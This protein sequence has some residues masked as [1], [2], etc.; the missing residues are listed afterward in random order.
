MTASHS[1]S[2]MFTSIRS[3][4]IPALFT[5][6][7]SPPNVSMAELMRRWAPSQSLTSSVLAM[8]SPPAATMSSTTC[9]AT[10]CIS[11]LPSASRPTSFTTTLAPS[12]ANS[13]ASSRPMPRPAPV[14][15]TT[16]PSQMP[17]AM[18]MKVGPYAAAMPPSQLP[19]PSIVWPLSDRGL[20]PRLMDLA[21]LP[22]VTGAHPFARQAFL[23]DV[24]S[25]HG[26]IPR[27]GEIERELVQD[28]GDRQQIVGG[29]GWQAHLVLVRRRP[30]VQVLVTAES[31]DL[32]DATLAGIKAAAPP[33]ERT[34]AQARLTL[35]TAG[36]GG[37][38]VRHRRW[39]D[40]PRWSAIE[41]NY[42][43]DVR[44]PLARVMSMPDGPTTGGRLLLWYGEPGT[45]KTT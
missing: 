21:T 32:A 15:I 31:A 2:V 45:G 4:R 42:P 22:F 34:D 29:E 12:A 37:S 10:G 23:G 18:R 7:S 44:E 17:F 25:L 30:E 35:W 41:R 28:N 43:A 36:T 33:P 14:T 40:A 27:G 13:S 3:R 9:C 24:D 6:V 1:S 26:L 11:P 39:V 20:A 16:R 19:T 8:A 38:P 5:S